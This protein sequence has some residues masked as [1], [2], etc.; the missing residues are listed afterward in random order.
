MT[1]TEIYEPNPMKTSYKLLIALAFLATAALVIFLTGLLLAGCPLLDQIMEILPDPTSYD[2]PG[3]GGDWDPDPEFSSVAVSRQEE[4]I[5]YDQDAWN[6]G[7]SDSIGALNEFGQGMS[8]SFTT[9]TNDT[10]TGIAGTAQL[11]NAWIGDI[12]MAGSIVIWIFG[13]TLGIAT[14]ATGVGKD[15]IKLLIIAAIAFIAVITFGIGFT[16]YQTMNEGYVTNL[17]WIGAFSGV[18]LYFDFK[19]RAIYALLLGIIPSA[20][21]VVWIW[22]DAFAGLVGG[23]RYFLWTTWQPQYY[24]WLAS[25]GV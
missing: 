2:N 16:Y 25:W 15:S 7:V 9:G 20:V 8:D 22:P 5:Y 14:A 12:F 23:T 19:Q 6:E 11:I 21:I 10:L 18:Y 24:A 13:F 1:K 3:L 4:I 17:I